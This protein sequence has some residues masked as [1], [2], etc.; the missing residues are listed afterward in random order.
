MRRFVDEIVERKA[1]FFV[2]GGPKGPSTVTERKGYV[3]RER[4]DTAAE[5]ERLG[6]E[7]RLVA[8]EFVCPVHGRFTAE[9]DEQCDEVACAK[10]SWCVWSSKVTLPDDVLER[11]WPSRMALEDH[12]TERGIA[13]GDLSF[14]TAACGLTSPWSPSTVGVGKSSGDVTC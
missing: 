13:W 3:L 7:P 1:T 12:L 6:V 9:T 10:R 5:R 2:P 8:R 11:E 14:G 4:G